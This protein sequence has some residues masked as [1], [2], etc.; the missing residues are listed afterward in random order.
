MPCTLF[1]RRGEP[2]IHPRQ[3][4]TPLPAPPPVDPRDATP[5]QLGRRAQ[6]LAVQGPRPAPA[7]LAGAS[8]RDGPVPTWEEARRALFGNRERAGLVE[9]CRNDE[10]LIAAAQDR[11]PYLAA[12]CAQLG[13]DRLAYAPIHVEE[14]D[15]GGRELDRLRAEYEAMAAPWEERRRRGLALEVRKCGDLSK[16]D[17]AEALRDRLS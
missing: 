14:N 6:Q 9:R 17:F 8:D 1:A 15:R 5:A 16:P 3:P 13:R 4:Q 12:Y 2:V 11:H 7:E 10:C